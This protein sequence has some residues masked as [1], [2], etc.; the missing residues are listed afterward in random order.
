MGNKVY[1]SG[2]NTYSID[3]N[4]LTLVVKDKDDNQT[5]IPWVSLTRMQAQIMHILHAETRRSEQLRP[6]RCA[7][8]QE[9]PTH[10]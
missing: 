10:V 3:K 5:K 2:G 4:W 6:A 1:K 8:P 9:S 7:Q